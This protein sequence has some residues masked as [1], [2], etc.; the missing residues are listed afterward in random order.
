M[1]TSV[2]ELMLLQEQDARSC[3]FSPRTRTL[4]NFIQKLA[5]ARAEAQA[6]RKVEGTPIAA[7]YYSVLNS[8][9]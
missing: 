6:G 3:T 5:A 2:T 9:L 8:T 1:D 7:R 4:P